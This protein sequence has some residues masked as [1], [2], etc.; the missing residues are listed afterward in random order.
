MLLLQI[1]TV[2]KTYDYRL[3]IGIQQKNHQLTL[4]SSAILPS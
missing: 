3:G 1:T 4:S 2:G